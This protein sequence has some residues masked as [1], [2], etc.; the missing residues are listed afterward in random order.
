MERKRIVC[1]TPKKIPDATTDRIDLFWAEVNLQV[2]TE[3]ATDSSLLLLLF[4][5]HCLFGTDYLSHMMRSAR[6]LKYL[7]AARLS[8][9]V[10]HSSSHTVDV[11]RHAVN[12]LAASP[13][14]SIR[15]SING[16]C[17]RM[18]SRRAPPFR[19]ST[20]PPR[21]AWWFSHPH[22]YA[23]DNRTCD[24]CVVNRYLKCRQQTCQRPQNTFW[25]GSTCQNQMYG[26]SSCNQN[27][28][29]CLA[30]L[31]LTRVQANQCTIKGT[32]SEESLI[33]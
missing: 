11:F 1:F 13:L 14:I 2:D 8:C 31:N 23:A 6:S 7:L 22:L 24:H 5:C 32:F 17:M 10:C 15:K 27:N 20:P 28:N 12:S 3:M 26:S 9:L 30:S 29:C 16:D 18:N 21:L 19:L 4:H 33:E 25:N